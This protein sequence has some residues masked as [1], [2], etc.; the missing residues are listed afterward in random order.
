MQAFP[1]FANE[2]R[3]PAYYCGR[4]FDSE[5]MCGWL[6]YSKLVLDEKTKGDRREPESAFI[7]NLID[8]QEMPQSEIKMVK[9]YLLFKYARILTHRIFPRPI[10]EFLRVGD[11]DIA[12]KGLF[13]YIHS[14]KFQVL[15]A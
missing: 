14:L 11:E 13:I 2:A 5:L 6:Y 3:I 15:E 9:L 10:L 8:E 12:N 7:Q 4:Q 1:E